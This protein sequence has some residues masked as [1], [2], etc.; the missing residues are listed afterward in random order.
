LP[1]QAGKLWVFTAP[2]EG[3]GQFVAELA[4][5]T[6]F[7][8]YG[9]N[10][11]IATH[12]AGAYGEYMIEV[13]ASAGARISIYVD[14]PTG[15]SSPYTLSAVWTRTI[16]PPSLA[17]APP[18][19]PGAVLLA[20]DLSDPARGI[21]TSR[22]TPTWSRGYDNGS[23]RMRTLD[24]SPNAV[25][26]AQ[27]PG[28][29]V[30]TVL[31]ITAA[32]I[33]DPGD[34][35]S[36]VAGCRFQQDEGSD[37][38]LLIQPQARTFSLLRIEGGGYTNLVSAT[39]SEAIRRGAQANRIQLACV[40]NVVA[41]AINGIPVAS[42]RDDAFADGEL[43]VGVYGQGTTADVRFNDI[44]VTSGDPGALPGPVAPPTAGSIIL[45]DNFDDPDRGFVPTRFTE[46]TYV[47]G[48]RDGEYVIQKVEA[49]GNATRFISAAGS[50]TDVAIA[51]DARIVGQT[52]DRSPSLACRLDS[53]I[54]S[55]YQFLV[56]P[57]DSTALLR[58]IDRGA[59]S[60]I[61]ELKSS[62]A[63]R[64]GTERNRLEMVCAGGTIQGRVNGVTV[65][66]A[67][68]G[69]YR[70]GTVGFGAGGVGLFDIRFDNF[71]VTQR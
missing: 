60:T 43:F 25:P 23:Y 29:Y 51:V 55:G 45:T 28:V 40:G 41:V 70:S 36:I 2:A 31:E 6:R 49:Q 16:T 71:V 10:G 53:Q 27:L 66:E 44:V 61:A 13:S 14:N 54:V 35:P 58:R 65:V 24:P 67:T 15:G 37:Y 56:V 68:E 17:A 38:R 12:E 11:L 59:F 33:G 46:S 50:Y 9:P 3:S 48:Y 19:I 4:P 5:G 47:G 22:S 21:L 34:D 7:Y 64:P 52:V 26:I 8:A 69:T 63:V 39:V 42:V 62:S 1:P 18:P 20:D 32:N 57:A 30:D